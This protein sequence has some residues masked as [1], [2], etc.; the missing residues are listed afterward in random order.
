MCL[1][2]CKEYVKELYLEPCYNEQSRPYSKESSLGYQVSE[3]EI[4]DYW[5]RVESCNMEIAR[6]SMMCPPVG[7]GGETSAAADVA[8]TAAMTTALLMI[9]LFHK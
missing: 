2:E 6:E 8:S 1:K 9:T 4:R 5:L 7:T 3:K